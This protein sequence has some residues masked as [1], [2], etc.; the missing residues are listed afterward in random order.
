[1]TASSH[2]PPRTRRG[3]ANQGTAAWQYAIAG[4]LF[5][6]AFPVVA[7][8]IRVSQSGAAFG[9]TAIGRAQ[10]SDPLLWIIDTAPLFLGLLAMLAGLRQDAA[11]ARN[12]E[13]EAREQE[14]SNIQA[15]LESRVAERTRD[16]ENRSS[17]LRDAVLLTRKLSSFG[18]IRALLAAA[19]RDLAATYGGYR[20]TFYLVD[21]PGNTGALVASSSPEQQAG[22]DSFRVGD[23]TIQGRAAAGGEGVVVPGGGTEITAM[24][25]PLIVRSRTVGVLVMAAD[26][27]TRARRAPRA[28][29]LQVLA[30]QIA[31]IVDSAQ[32][33]DQTRSALDQL[34]TL[35]GQ[36]AGRAWRDF[37]AEH[38]V[39]YEYTPG[40]V[41]RVSQGSPGA[42]P[43]WMQVPLTVRGREVGSLAMRRDP[44]IQWTQGEVDLARQVATQV[45]SALEN[46]RLLIEADERASR[47]QKIAE[48]SSRLGTSVDVDTLLQTAAQEIAGLPGVAEATVILAPDEREPVAGEAEG[49]LHGDDV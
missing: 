11:T 46:V 40:S 13:L 29:L 16:I 6:L 14:L 28:E 49:R 17:E 20:A 33:L 3:L 45:G 10:G 15:T 39:A 4:A 2:Q 24:A 22:W 12:V 27:N 23:D 44:S 21:E 18:D 35:A 42:G 34:Q 30:D 47:Q 36:S 25:L 5:G 37:A 9:L 19:A 7:T 32:L 41:H 1:M 43:E 26:P 8:A 31:A 38:P 48:L